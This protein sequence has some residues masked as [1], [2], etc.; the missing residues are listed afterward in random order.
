MDVIRT[1]TRPDPP[2]TKSFILV[3]TSFCNLNILAV[4]Q[5]VLSIHL[6]HSEIS[7]I[8]LDT[9]FFI[10]CHNGMCCCYAWLNVEGLLCILVDVAIF[11]AVFPAIETFSFIIPKLVKA[12]PLFPLREIKPVT[13]ILT[14]TRHGKRLTCA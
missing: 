1:V 7:P 5:A 14:P 6:T 4:V 10:G 2:C 11:C 13:H 8:D 12:K 3:I 9:V